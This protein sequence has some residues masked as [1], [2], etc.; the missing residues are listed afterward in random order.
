MQRE[1]KAGRP[2]SAP[3]RSQTDA[4]TCARARARAHSCRQRPARAGTAKVAHSPSM[5]AMSL[6][7]SSSD[8]RPSLWVLAQTMPLACCTSPRTIGQSRSTT[9]W[10]FLSQVCRECARSSVQSMPRSPS[11][12]SI[13]LL[14]ERR[15]FSL[16]ASGFRI[17]AFL[18]IML[19]TFLKLGR[20][21]KTK[22]LHFR[23]SLI[24]S[25]EA[26]LKTQVC[27]FHKPRLFITFLAEPQ[28]P[29]FRPFLDTMII[30][31]SFLAFSPHLET[32][33]KRFWSS[34]LVLASFTSLS[35][36]MIPWPFSPAFLRFRTCAIFAARSARALRFMS[37]RLRTTSATLMFSPG[38]RGCKT[39][40]GTL[41]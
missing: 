17:M 9:L 34:L 38:R 26:A 13:R 32:L 4:H 41:L 14:S 16:G 18:W 22:G 29:P 40:V 21:Q 7:N 20:P 11:C 8:C 2:T 1:K 19:K 24:S 23:R 27:F 35:S 15:I 33:L 31:G 10:K 28:P 37:R 3:H 39:A 36:R 30:G 5:E 6:L 12:S 25:C